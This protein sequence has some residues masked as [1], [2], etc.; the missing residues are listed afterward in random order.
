MNKIGKLLKALG[1]IARKPYLLNLVLDE[2]EAWRKRVWKEYGTEGLDEI[3]LKELMEGKDISI[4]PFAFMEGGSLPTDLALLRCLASR[5]ESCNYF[6]IG[7]WR[8]ESVANV[9][10]VAN[11]CTTMNLAPA[12]MKELGLHDDY[13]RQYAMFS[14]ELAN[15][16]H[17]E[18]DSLTFD[19]SSLGQQFDLIFIDGD[20]HYGSVKK[21]TENVF[22]HLVHNDSIVVWHDYAWHPAEIRFECLAAILAGVPTHL[23][24]NIYAVRNTMCAVYFPAEVS[25]RSPSS[26]ALREE[27][28]EL[29]IK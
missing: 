16:T 8:G 15:V 24:N 25:S 19:F 18:E 29:V 1:M 3:S 23:R 28:F 13:I 27:A 10:E 21:D 9:A 11:Y 7:T 4:K 6:E 26:L 2:N 17:L 5:F 12:R 22:K 20:H 14:K